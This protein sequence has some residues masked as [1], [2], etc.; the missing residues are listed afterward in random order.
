M[1]PKSNEQQAIL[2]PDIRPWFREP[3][4]WLIIALPAT[5]IVGCAITIWLAI[6]RP[7]YVV[8]DDVEYRQIKSELQAVPGPIQQSSEPAVKPPETID[9]DSDG[10]G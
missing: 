5:A 4:V 2:D 1:N 7:D 10:R 8:V 6:T 3:W 9:S